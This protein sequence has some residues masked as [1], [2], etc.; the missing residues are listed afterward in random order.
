ME[1]VLSTAESVNPDLVG[2]IIPQF[3]ATDQWRD[4]ARMEAAHGSFATAIFTL[5]RTKIDDDTVARIALERSIPVITMSRKRHNPELVK[6]LAELGVDVLVH[7][8]NKPDEIGAYLDNGVR[9]IYSDRF[10]S[11][12]GFQRAIQKKRRPPQPDR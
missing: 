12:A 5:Y 1:E 6:R 7:T 9:G 2:R 10:V 3:Y 8:V 11:R 4:V